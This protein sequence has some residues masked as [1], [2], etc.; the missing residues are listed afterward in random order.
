MKK[1]HWNLQH[2]FSVFDVHTW[3][4]NVSCSQ[5]YFHILHPI[6]IIDIKTLAVDHCDERTE[7]FISLFSKGK[8]IS[9]RNF[10]VSKSPKNRTFFLNSSNKLIP[11]RKI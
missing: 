9:E 6:L 8:L 5:T 1:N 4:K 11:F 2:L 3:E 7:T 10:G